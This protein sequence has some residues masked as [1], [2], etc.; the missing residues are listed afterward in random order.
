M[1]T[2]GNVGHYIGKEE[3]DDS[4]SALYNR[5]TQSEKEVSL[6]PTSL[7]LSLSFPPLVQINEASSRQRNK[8]KNWRRRRRRRTPIIGKSSPSKR[9]KEEKMSQLL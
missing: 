3:K 6:L 8:G 4:S 9:R 5:D 2:K 7:S 1:E